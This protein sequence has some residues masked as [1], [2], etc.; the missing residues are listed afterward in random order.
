ML[1]PKEKR[2]INIKAPYIDEISES[3]IFKVLDKKTWNML[4]HKVKFV[5]NLATS[6]VAYKSLETVIFNP[7]NVKNIRFKVNRI[8]Q[9]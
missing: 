8:L 1:K 5:R 3:V 2:F 7:K 4:M 9:D 6:D